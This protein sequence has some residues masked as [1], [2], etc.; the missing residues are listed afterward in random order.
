MSRLNKYREYN[1][2]IIWKGNLDDDC[3]ANWCG[4][5][6]RAEW[7]DEESWWWCVYDMLDDENQIDSSNEYTEVCTKGENARRK[8]EEIAQEYLKNELVSLTKQSTDS[9]KIEQLIWALKMIRYSPIGSMKILRFN[10]DFEYHQA[11]N[12]VFDSPHWVGARESS[13]ALTQMF[14][15]A[16]AESADEVEYSEDGLIR[17]VHIDLTKDQPKIEEPEKQSFW[18]RVKQRIKK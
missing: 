1:Q 7:M 18:S 14:L 15:Q 10:F 9:D 5:M 11:Q 4:L 16:A 2:E 3:T 12:I 17:S 6:L 13:E 8:A